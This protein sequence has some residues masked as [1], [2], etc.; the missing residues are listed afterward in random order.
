MVIRISHNYANVNIVIG[1]KVVDQDLKAGMS[2]MRDEMN[3][4]KAENVSLKET[5]RLIVEAITPPRKERDD[6]FAE[7]EDDAAPR[8]NLVALPKV[9]GGHVYMKPFDRKTM[10]RRFTQ[11][12]EKDAWTQA[13]KDKIKTAFGDNVLMSSMTYELWRQLNVPRDMGRELSSK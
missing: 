9:G 1:V 12:Q 6:D 5:M 3:T 11:E 8:V 2:A 7:L 13:T 10:F 4:I